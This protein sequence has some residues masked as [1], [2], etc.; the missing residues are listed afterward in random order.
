VSSFA[1]WKLYDDFSSGSIDTQKWNVISNPLSE[2]ISVENGA[3]KFVFDTDNK[4]TSSWLSFPQSPEKIKGV[5]VKVMF[6]SAV[7]G[8]RARIG[9]YS[10][11]DP[12]GNLVWNQIDL[13]QSTSDGINYSQYAWYGISTSDPISND[14]VKSYLYGEFPK[15]LA[16]TYVAP[17]DLTNEWITIE[18]QFNPKKFSCGLPDPDMNWYL[19]KYKPL[20]KITKIDKNSDP[21]LFFKGI[22]VR[23]NNSAPDGEECTVYFDDVYVLQ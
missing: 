20:I 13:V 15:P 4:N 14:E 6:A 16:G 1:G 3:A 21:D 8:V 7:V 17:V 19:K 12:L 11:T 10:G 18:I 23:A 5:R 22:G 9:G 2:P